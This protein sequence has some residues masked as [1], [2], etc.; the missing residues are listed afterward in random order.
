MSLMRDI[1]KIKDLSAAVKLGDESAKKELEKIL[2]GTQCRR[3]EQRR[4]NTRI[5]SV[6]RRKEDRLQLIAEICEN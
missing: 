5:D 6:E 1:D 4:K 3:V 2:Q